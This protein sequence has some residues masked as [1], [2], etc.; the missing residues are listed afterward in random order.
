MNGFPSFRIEP[1]HTVHDS[2]VT[3]WR[4]EDREF[5]RRKLREWFD[6][7]L[8]IAGVT[9]TIPVDS[10]VGPDWGMAEGEPL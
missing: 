5:A 8:T 3:Q 4:K 7:P 2:L 6:N 10:E 1:L 9:V